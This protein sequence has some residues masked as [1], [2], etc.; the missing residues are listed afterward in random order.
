MGS[1]FG[2]EPCVMRGI[3][4][5]Q[6]L[7]KS[8]IYDDDTLF[9]VPKNEREIEILN[10]YSQATLFSIYLI[11]Q[12]PSCYLSDCLG[13]RTSFYWEC[14]VLLWNIAGSYVLSLWGGSPYCGCTARSMACSHRL[15]CSVCFSR[16]TCSPCSNLLLS[17]QVGFLIYFQILW[18]G[19]PYSRNNWVAGATVVPSM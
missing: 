19:L 2:M 5:R 12:I 16:L 1:T 10:G 7:N 13:E 15:T 8:R 6:I 18:V 17:F 11:H 9:F 3:V 14:A 4:F